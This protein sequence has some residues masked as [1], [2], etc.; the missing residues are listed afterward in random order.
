MRTSATPPRRNRATPGFTLLELVV[1]LALLGLATALVAPAG[2]RMI[3]TW[4]RATDVD[5][6]MGTLVALGAQARLQGRAIHLPMGDIARE[7]LP[8]LPD[9]WT[10]HLEVPL[11][12]QANGAC[13]E[14]R[15]EMRQEGYAR[16]FVL[17]AP[18]CRG[19]LPEAP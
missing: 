11:T 14:T 15:G 10:V 7:Q 1:V 2:F 5:A 8:T 17:H 4:R 3:A 9:G 18:F 19:E 13:S 6:V 16:A 12:V